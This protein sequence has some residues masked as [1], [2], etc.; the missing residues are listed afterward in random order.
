MTKPSMLDRAAL[1]FCIALAFLV[2]GLHVKK[3]PPLSPIDELQHLDYVYKA[4]SGHVVAQGER[5]GQDALRD[6]VCRGLDASFPLPACDAPA[7][8][9]PDDFQE[10]G[11]NTA[12]VHPPTYYFLTGV[13]AKV[14]HAITGDGTHTA[15]RTIGAGWLGLAV[16]LIWRLLVHRRANPLTQ[17]SLLSLLIVS[18]SVIF[19]SSTTS[20]DAS[21]LL[22]GAAMLAAVLW[23]E[24]DILPAW[25]MV[26][27]VAFTLGLKFTHIGA[28]GLVVVYLAVRAVQQAPLATWRHDPVYRRYAR[29]VLLVL[30][31]SFA[32]LAVWTG[33]EKVVAVAS[34]DQIQM[35]QTLHTDSFPAAQVLENVDATFS[36]LQAPYFTPVLR[37]QYVI[38]L[39]H[40]LDVSVLLA[41]ASVAVFAAARTR[42]R[43][44]GFATAVAML[45]LGPVTV[46]TNYVSSSA[47][48]SI[49][50]RYGLPI[51]PAALV[52]AVPAME[53]PG[54]RRSVAAFAT[55]AVLIVVLR[56][57][58]V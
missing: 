3:Y 40:V 38:G 10:R 15:A 32:M 25:V 54:I 11:Y 1:L 26:P 44:L 47:V 31:T 58:R 20:P 53:R 8:L 36:P 16:W 18:P 5:I 22:A 23:W 7:P 9:N 30:A 52:C 17:V 50:S 2:V 41:V 6:E 21:S 55:L 28:I 33:I 13:A 56:M 49:P 37:N 57:V 45:T 34:S 42:E 24:D 43:A 19:A 27:A 46:V 14:E 39:N 29:S 35:T 48:T 51:V 4:P 12:Y